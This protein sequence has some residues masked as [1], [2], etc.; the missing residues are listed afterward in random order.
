M[1]YLFFII[2]SIFSLYADEYYYNLNNYLIDKISES[3]GY[4]KRLKK[5]IDSNIC[6]KKSIKYVK[7]QKEDGLKD[8]K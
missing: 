2:V 1:R 6:F 3:N 4:C 5:S 8:Y 7:F